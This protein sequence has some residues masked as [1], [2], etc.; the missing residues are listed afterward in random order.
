MEIDRTDFHT[1]NA[2]TTTTRSINLAKN[3][4]LRDTCSEGKIRSRVTGLRVQQTNSLGGDIMGA[5]FLRDFADERDAARL[6]QMLCAKRREHGASSVQ[7]PRSEAERTW[8]F[9]KRLR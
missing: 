6:A 2:S 9:Q 8:G 3:N 1:P 4:P 5:P 7:M